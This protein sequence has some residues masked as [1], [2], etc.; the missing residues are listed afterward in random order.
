MRLVI[1]SNNK[2]K[3]KEIKMILSDYY[4]DIVSMGEAGCFDEIEEYGKTF[5]ENSYIKA[6]Y[7]FDK[8]GCAALAD[9]SGLEVDALDGEP[10]VYSARYAGQHGKDEA[11][12]D[13]LLAV[14]EEIDDDKRGAQFVSV[15]SLVQPD[16]TQISAKG[17]CRGKILRQ[18]RGDGGFGYDPIFYIEELG[19]TMAELTM[20]EKNKISHRKRAL[21]GLKE[22]LQKK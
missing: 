13:K 18:R 4:D 14:M 10:G 11:N 20:E 6:K 15:V 2:H 3:V 22:K 8:L 12:N 16:G 21:Q 17:I 19:K 9:D 1:A 5:E 7:V